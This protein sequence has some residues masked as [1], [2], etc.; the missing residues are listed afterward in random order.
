VD[1]TVTPLQLLADKLTDTPGHIVAALAVSVGVVGGAEGTLMAIERT[2]GL[3]P[4]PA[5]VQV[6]E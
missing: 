1:Q 4:D 2:M 5:T 3:Q 6:T